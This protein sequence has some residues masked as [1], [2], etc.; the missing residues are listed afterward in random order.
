MQKLDEKAKLELYEKYH[1][2]LCKLAWSFHY[3]TNIDVEELLDE[4][5]LA[6]FLGLEK[7]EADKSTLSTFLHT[8]VT[9]HLI[10][11][12][13]KYHRIT[14][15]S[16]LIESETF[17]ESM[18]YDPFSFIDNMN[19]L[20]EEAQYVCRTILTSPEKFIESSSRLARKHVIDRLRA[21]K[22][23]WPKIWRTIKEI[24]T[25]LN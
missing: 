9:N 24:K 3:S 12:T 15:N 14:P 22:W 2:M 25:A 4:V 23:S 8:F 5:Q 19:S 18:Y 13:K 7:Y 20:S 1:K 11:F 21:E 6:F 17:A 10:D 16:N